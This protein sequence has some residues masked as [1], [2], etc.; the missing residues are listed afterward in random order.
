MGFSHRPSDCGVARLVRARKSKRAQTAE[1]TY[2]EHNE[3][4][5]HAPKRNLEIAFVS[6]ARA[7][8]G[9]VIQAAESSIGGESFQW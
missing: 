2:I 9:S 6:G 1:Q 8:W 7:N 4:E 5:R 3:N